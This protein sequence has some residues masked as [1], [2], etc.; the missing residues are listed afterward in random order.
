MRKLL[1]IALGLWCAF[2]AFQEFNKPDFLNYF[3]NLKSLVTQKAFA[4]PSYPKPVG[5]VNDFAGIISGNVEQRLEQELRDY[6]RKTSIEIAIAT[7]PD[8]QGYSIDEW[9]E[10]L[11]QKWGVGKKGLD[12]G[13]LVCVA[14]NERKWGIEVGYGLEGNITDGMAGSLGRENLVPYFRRGDFGGG[15]SALVDSIISHLGNYSWAEREKRYAQR[16]EDERIAR[17]RRAEEAQ[18]ARE[19]AAEE[20][21]IRDERFAKT[22]RTLLTFGLIFAVLAAFAITLIVINIRRKRFLKLVQNTKDIHGKIKGSISEVEDFLFESKSKGFKVD[23]ELKAV[24]EASETYGKIS[25]PEGIEKS[26]SYKSAFEKLSKIS[27]GLKLVKEGFEAKLESMK[28][29]NEYLESLP[30]LIK[31][32]GDMHA[33]QEPYLKELK[34]ENPT[35]VWSNVEKDFEAVPS[36][37]NSLESQLDKVAKLSSMDVQEFV[38]AETLAQ[39]IEKSLKDI[40][41]LLDIKGLLESIARAKARVPDLHE[42]A[43]KAV[44]KALKKAE[45]SDVS[46]ST[47]DKAKQ[48]RK[49]L[50]KA[51]AELD[52]RKVNWILVVSLLEEAK[53]EAEEAYKEAKEEISRAESKRSS[54]NNIIII[55]GGSNYGGGGGGFGGFSGGSSGGGSG[56][57]GGFGGGSSGGGGASGS[58]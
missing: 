23:S 43:E 40:G 37:L 39:S 20:K 45:D 15:I 55:G 36:E 4:A 34:A 52:E 8:L 9:R 13:L 35:A 10:G 25:I 21:R 56:G 51:E 58:W 57:F 24:D 18:I 54:N 33:K 29:A 7:I 6:E 27:E 48:A 17:E 19:R 44:N 28:R 31:K 38:K 5:H 41:S 11:F 30:K 47:E 1:L 3:Y 46:S 53:S 26:F 2:F 12:N 50:K 22:M 16:A 32:I 42:N 49:K 14:P